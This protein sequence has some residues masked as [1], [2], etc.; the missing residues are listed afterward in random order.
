MLEHSIASKRTS[1]T[2]CVDSRSREVSLAPWH[3]FL[4]LFF[5]ED[6]GRKAR[7][8]PQFMRPVIANRFPIPGL[9]DGVSQSEWRPDFVGLLLILEPISTFE[10]FTNFD[11]ALLALKT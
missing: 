6:Q 7:E 3:S 2:A 10:S 8:I 5:S 9:R 11:Q 4:S 1:K